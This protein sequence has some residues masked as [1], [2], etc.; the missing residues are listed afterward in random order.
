MRAS[1]SRF[2][3]A[4]MAVTFLGSASAIVAATPPASA[5][6]LPI[7][8]SRVTAGYEVDAANLPP[9]NVTTQF[10]VP[11][12]ACTKAT[13]RSGFGAFIQDSTGLVTGTTGVTVGCVDGQPSFKAFATINGR[14][15]RLKTTVLTGDLVTT[16]ETQT[17]S[18]TTDTFSDGRTGFTRSVVGPGG[19]ARFAFIGR[20][21]S[22]YEYE[23]MFGT[24][25][26]TNVV[27]TGANGENLGSYIAAE[28]VQEQIQTTGG[29]L[30]PAGTIQVQPSA[31][32]PSSFSLVWMHQ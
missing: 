12:V 15:T 9:T 2:T 27:V 32:G 4:L 22:K 5:A 31:L 13:R 28:D 17:S 8:Y 30:P 26:F 3:V 14:V 16:T 25:S 29:R 19:S 10:R 1:A 18:T 24:V 21:P 6:S 11:N 7:L 23:P 20:L